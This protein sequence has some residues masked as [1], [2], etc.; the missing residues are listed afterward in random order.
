MEIE[1]LS[2]VQ[3]T[4]AFQR[5]A[6]AQYETALRRLSQEAVGRE[7][8]PAEIKL[9]AY[10]YLARFEEE[11]EKAEEHI[12]AVRKLAARLKRPSSSRD[13]ELSERIAGR[14]AGRRAARR[15]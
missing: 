5:A 3:L 9:A 2:E 14:F 11:T 10:T 12:S 7:S 15:R 6:A 8:A 1:R 4:Q 13:F